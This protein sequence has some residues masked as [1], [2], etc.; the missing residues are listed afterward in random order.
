[1]TRHLAPAPTLAHYGGPPPRNYQRYFV[2]AIGLPL[3][4]EL[5]EAAAL[6]TG[7]RVV[8]VACGTGIVARLAAEQVGSG[9]AVTGVDVNPGMLAVARSVPAAGA[10]IDW[11]EA[12]AAATGLPDAAS[13]V[14]LCQ[15]GLQFFA[16]RPAALWELRRLLKP[17]GRIVVSVAGPASPMFEVLERALADHVSPEAAGFVATV[18]SL[19]ESSELER[20]LDGAG[21]D[22]ISVERRARRLRLPPPAEFLWQYVSST[23]L[24]PAL[25]RLDETARGALARD[26]VAQWERF[27]GD[28]GQMILELD[29]LLATARSRHAVSR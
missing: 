27:A 12:D 21:F 20:L 9:G 16:D 14:A 11:H 4:A 6:H 7:E 25:G 15:L 2:P 5:V 19:S 26:V 28:D 24:A 23:P 10:A 18:F 13:D 17:G 3:A 1:M 22:A 29:V 8:D